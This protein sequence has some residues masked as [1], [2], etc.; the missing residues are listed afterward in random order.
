MH[1]ERSR[2][3]CIPSGD[4]RSI[5]K[6]L[7]GD[8]AEAVLC[9]GAVFDLTAPIEFTNSHQIIYT[10]GDPIGSTRAT[11]R[12]VHPSVATAVNML[13]Q[14][15]AELSHVMID[16]N[17]KELGRTDAMSYG[18][19]LIRA[20]D[21]ATGQIVRNVDV[22]D[23]RTW[24]ILHMTEGDILNRCAGA[25]MENNMF[26]HVGNHT[27][28]FGANGISMACTHSIVRN[29]TIIDASDVGLVLFGA[30]GSIIEDNEI[31]SNSQAINV[32]I[33]LV[34]FGPF[35]GSFNGT[36]VRGNVIKAKNATIGVGVAMGPRISQCMNEGYVTEH[37]LW[38][39][40]VTGNVLMGEHMQYGFAID[41]VKDWTVMGNIDN[42]KHVGEPLMSCHGSDLPSAPDGFLVDRTTST[43]V[44]QAE[45]QNAKNLESIFSVARREHTRLACI[46]SGDQDTIMRELVGQFAEVSLCQGV[47]LNLTA[48]IKFTD[49]HQKIYTQG[50][51]IDNKR[52]TLRIV[53]P[54]VATA[55]NML[56]QD[57]VELSHV[58]ID[59]NRPEF[60]RTDAISYGDALIRA[61]GE[62]LG[63]SFAI[64]MHGRHAAGQSCI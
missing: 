9:P 14:D 54:S 44:F 8:F 51:P 53:D 23:A 45:F 20:G 63:R 64:L 50:H 24:S 5:N 7:V 17:R 2:T 57:Y 37:L 33:S 59:G 28:A 62:L 13:S 10:Q 29:N 58:I 36:I 6:A 41:G 1:F 3:S 60:R 21:E 19:A 47:V 40:V 31:I 32:G 56:N 26:G 35:D 61:G 22:W 15:Y 25:L 49:R 46:L 16:W 43:G 4:Q 34:D 11:L 27:P 48:P 18:D 39:A 30:L 55:V 52:A 12:I 42:A 38:G